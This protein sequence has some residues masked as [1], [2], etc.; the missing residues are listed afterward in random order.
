MKTSRRRIYG[1]AVAVVVGV[2]G[3]AVMPQSASAATAPP[4]P[5]DLHEIMST[6]E[7]GTVPPPSF[8]DGVIRGGGIML[9]WKGDTS[10][11]S[12]Y[13]IYRVDGGRHDLV[14]AVYTTWAALSKSKGPF[15]ARCYEVAATLGTLASRPSGRWC[16]GRDS[17]PTVK[18]FTPSQFSSLSTRRVG[19]ERGNDA[20][21]LNIQGSK[22]LP[23]LKSLFGPLFASVFSWIGAGIDTGNTALP[24]T[25][26]TQ[27]SVLEVGAMGSTFVIDSSTQAFSFLQCGTLGSY[28]TTKNY[29]SAYASVGVAF[30]LR[31][32]SARRVF[33]A[34][35]T[36]GMGQST[37]TR[38]GKLTHIS[39]TSARTG[40]TLCVR[41]A[42]PAVSPWWNAADLNL[43]AYRSK[44]ASFALGP[45]VSVRADVTSIVQTWANDRD[46]G[47][48]GFILRGNLDPTA[49]PGVLP[50]PGLA[51]CMTQYTT[52][53]L[54]V[55][56][57]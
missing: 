43:W 6:K 37:V 38:S 36:M 45:G 9:A 30:P 23:G 28:H 12:T 4:A 18:T 48:N 35:L 29:A 41:D 55:V 24:W 46:A 33:S 8:C 42:D 22:I 10:V 47:D 3:I 17:T 32:L 11:P 49:P 39:G 56:Y 26:T 40:D 53:K 54:D 7:C 16:A 15:A 52:P 5:R 57:F 25:K 13:T 20:C 2:I 51:A 50:S 27:S 44:K 21:G 19:L 1:V 14:I 34:T 31:E